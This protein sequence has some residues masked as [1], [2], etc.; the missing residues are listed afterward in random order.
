MEK[1]DKYKMHK[2]KEYKDQV[3]KM[4]QQFLKM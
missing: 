1:Q 2:E 4:D 3:A